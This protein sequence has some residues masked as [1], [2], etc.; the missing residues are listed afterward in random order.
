[1]KVQDLFEAVSEGEQQS[2]IKHFALYAIVTDDEM[3]YSDFDSISV[4]TDEKSLIKRIKQ[5]FA[6]AE[7]DVELEN[8]S[9]NK[10]VTHENWPDF[11]ENVWIK[12]SL[13]DE[14]KQSM[15]DLGVTR[16]YL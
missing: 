12:G 8:L 2:D 15:K 6:Y 16:A 13:F 1:M 14:F 11:Y 3:N 4:Y 5:D 7:K 10:V 9:I